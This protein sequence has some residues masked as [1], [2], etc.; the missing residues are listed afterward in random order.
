[1][2]AE[3]QEK[4]IKKKNYFI[5]YDGYSCTH[6]A[7]SRSAVCR[8]RSNSHTAHKMSWTR[9]FRGRISKCSTPPIF[10]IP[11]AIDSCNNSLCHKRSHTFNIHS[12]LLAN[13]VG[14][15]QSVWIVFIFLSQY[16]FF[17]LSSSFLCTTHF[18]LV[19]RANGSRCVWKK[20]ISEHTHKHAHT[21]NFVYG[22]EWFWRRRQRHRN[23]YQNCIRCFVFDPC[24]CVVQLDSICSRCVC[25]LVGMF[26]SGVRY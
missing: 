10:N 14:I 16:K 19:L 1:M 8:Q 13:F 25:M 6:T 3:T 11:M 26:V 7:L 22:Y 4:N 5:F 21:L 17:F 2:S 20:I 15:V 12:D 18:S 23:S 24:L 9:L